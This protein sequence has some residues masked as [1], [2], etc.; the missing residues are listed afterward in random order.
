MLSNKRIARFGSAILTAALSL[1]AVGGSLLAADTPAKPKTT[2]QVSHQTDMPFEAAA[3]S[4]D[5]WQPIVTTKFRNTSQSMPITLESA[6]VRA[7]RNS[8]QVKVFSELPLI[9]ETAII[10]ADAAF[11]WH[12]F[13]DTRWDDL[14]DPVGN[15]LTTGSFG[16]FNDRQLSAVYGLRS[17]N[18]EGGQFEI[19]QEHGWQKNNS[20][21]FTY[22]GLRVPQSSAR[23]RMSYTHPLKRGSGRTYNES[24]ICLAKIDS[25]IAHEEFRRQLQQHLLEVVR[26]YWTI[27]ME[28]A[29]LVQKLQSYDRAAEVVERLEKRRDVDAVESQIASAKAVLELRSSELLRGRVGVRNA[30][31]RLRALLNDP[32]LGTDIEL[33][34]VDAPSSFEVPV[35]IQHALATALQSR[36]EVTQAMK[37]IK[38]SSIRVNMAK[39]ELMP[40]LNLITEAYISGLRGDDQL[41]RA[42]ADQ[43]SYGRPGYSIGLQYEMP[44]CNRA[45]KARYTR[46]HLELRQLNN[47]YR[48]TLATLRHEVELAVNEVNVGQKDMSAKHSAMEAAKRRLDYQEKRWQHLPGE[49][50]TA[51]LALENLL[52]SQERLAEA[53]R[54]YLDA[55]VIYNLAIPNLKKAQGVLLQQEAV[56]IGRACGN[57]LPTLQISKPD[58]GQPQQAIELQP[59]PAGIL[60]ATPVEPTPPAF[61]LP[62]GQSYEPGF[63][64]SGRV[65]TS[66]AES[67]N[68][69][70][71]S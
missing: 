4:S 36:P 58:L 65:E 11:D 26:G 62:T 69:A 5:W 53:E 12:A 30:E 20:N 45:A 57:G 35:D 49:D 25:E 29:I 6:L 23:L 56:Q 22:R 46:R 44:L 71:R 2:R 1:N 17:R 10:E 19:A 70:A 66:V 9:R 3:V 43:F 32:E 55:K 40:V 41:T 18:K 27:Y 31:G 24:L 54:S 28:R 61:E 47:Q 34:P 51:S 64:T 60:P 48:T 8:A 14:S 68:D 7:L 59:S 52:S 21:F 38:A 39:N 33:I 50:L 67:A 37:Q 15:S 42:W 13:A 16:R 63:G